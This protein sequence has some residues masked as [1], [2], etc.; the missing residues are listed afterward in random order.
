[1]K[2][3]IIYADPPWQYKVFDDSDAAHGAAKSHYQTMGLDDIK[4]LNIKDIAEDNAVLFMWATYPCLPEALEVIKSWGFKY[5]TVGFTWIKFD[6]LTD[7][8]LKLFLFPLISRE[9]IFKLLEKVIFCGIG[10]YTMSNAEICL[11]GT[12]GRLKRANKDVRQVI[13]SERAEHS[14]KPNEARER[15]VRLYGDLP[16]I[17]LFARESA[18]GWDVWGNEVNSTIDIFEKAI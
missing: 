8:I 2:Y 7:K 4:K 12:K 9:S 14:K 18:P 11:I 15:I 13:I 16:R 6:K 3:Q 5:K 17:E 1:M 10:H